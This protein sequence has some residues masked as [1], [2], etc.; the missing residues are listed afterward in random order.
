VNSL[1]RLLW[2]LPLVLA[3]GIAAMLVLRRFVR[4]GGHG[5]RDG[6]RLVSREQLALSD[7]TRVHLVEIDGQ[8]YLLIESTQHAV[9]QGLTPQ[10]RETIRTPGRSKPAWLHRLSGAAG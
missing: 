5:R 2:A 1:L 4:S 9:L 10:P 3:V 8:A 7:H 6:R